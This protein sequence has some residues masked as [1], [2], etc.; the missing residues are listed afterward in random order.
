MD[1][2]MLLQLRLP[3]SAHGEMPGTLLGKTQLTTNND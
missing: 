3:M 1:S 2:E